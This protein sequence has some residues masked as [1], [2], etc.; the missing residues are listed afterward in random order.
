[1]QMS[2]ASR[3][4]FTYLSGVI[5]FLAVVI[6]IPLVMSLYEQPTCFDGIQNQGETAPDRSGPCQ[7]LD[8]RTLIPHVVQW[9]RGFVVRPVGSAEGTWSSV[10]Y[11]ENPNEGAGVV[12]A[13]YRFRFYDDRNILITEREG[14]TYI[15]PASVTPVYEGA[16]E[17]GNREVARTFFE[18]TAPLVWERLTNTSTLIRVNGKAISGS[19]L[20]PR[21]TAIAENTDVR[22]LT[23]VE[24]VAVVFDTQGNAIAS[25]RTIIPRMEP[26]ARQDLA[27]TWPHPFTV[28]VGRLDVLPLR[29]PIIP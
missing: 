16:I 7:L 3:R 10:A 23:D 13:P 1:M 9:A 5:L 17:V 18:F 20:E 12:T 15:M 24:F 14:V 22:A 4:R 19:A 2:W 26:G 25:S 28:P 29:T 21:V 11:V 8:E 6:G 27:F